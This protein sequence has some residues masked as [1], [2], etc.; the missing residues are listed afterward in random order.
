[1]F[2][3]M[4]TFPYVPAPVMKWPNMV[5]GYVMADLAMNS[6]N[7]YFTDEFVLS[8]SKYLSNR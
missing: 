7:D 5:E 8:L 4:I 2:Q 1:M 3:S 6:S